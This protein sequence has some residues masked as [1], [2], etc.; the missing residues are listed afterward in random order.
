MKTSTTKMTGS[1][2]YSS[3]G[4]EILPRMELLFSL[5]NRTHHSFHTVPNSTS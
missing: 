1:K 3:I 4:P 5:T 2:I